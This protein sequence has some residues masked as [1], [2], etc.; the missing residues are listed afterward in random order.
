MLRGPNLG[1]LPDESNKIYVYLPWNL[2]FDSRVPFSGKI[3]ILV[4]CPSDGYNL[5]CLC[6]N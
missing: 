1:I 3:R 2:L 4:V 6:N 5:L